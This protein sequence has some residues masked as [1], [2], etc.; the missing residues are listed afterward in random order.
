[1]N[2]LDIGVLVLVALCALAGYR[3]GLIRTVYRLVS[4][5]VSMLLA[6]VLYPIVAGILR[7][8]PLF[9]TIADSV[10]GS[11]NLRNFVDEHAA[12]S[13]AEI[14]ESLPVPAQLRTM[15]NENIT[16]DYGEILQVE[17]MENYI[18]EFFA[19]IAINGI[20]IILVFMLVGIA[21]GV[22]G[23]LIDIVGKLPVIRT[24]NDIGGLAAGIVMG[25]GISFFTI[26]IMSMFFVTGASGEMAVL[27][28]ESLIAKIVMNS[29]LPRLSA[30][31]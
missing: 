3:Q 29:V 1:M 6:Y 13:Q 16:P 10:K 15:L 2:V 22:V 5:F 27:L 21:L 23:A 12:K 24:F 20:A 18:S 17:A 4:F 11:L 28:E 25:V 26:V 31:L 9:G 8:T 7:T 30:G 14:I 19:N